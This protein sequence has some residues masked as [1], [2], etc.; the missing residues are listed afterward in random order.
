[1]G[2]YCKIWRKNQMYLEECQCFSHFPSLGLSKTN[3]PLHVS[4]SLAT[5][6]YWILHEREWQDDYNVQWKNWRCKVTNRKH[7]Q[8]GI[9]KKDEYEVYILE[10]WW[11]LTR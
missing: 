5:L 11:K 3:L 9:L 4:N 1:M 2:D 6:A 8:D 10:M 7:I